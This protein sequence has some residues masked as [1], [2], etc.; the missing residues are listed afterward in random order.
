MS[1]GRNE[2]KQDVNAVVAEARIT[3]DT[4]LLRK[5]VIVLSLE[6]T[7]DLRE[8]I[9]RSANYYLRRRTSCTYLASLSIWSPKPGVSTMV[10]EMRV[11]S[12]S[13]SRSSISIRKRGAAWVHYY[14][15]TVMGWILTPSSKCAVVGSSESLC[16]RTFLPQRVLTKV[17][18]PATVMVSRA[19]SVGGS[20]QGANSPVPDAPQTIKQN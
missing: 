9:L 12:S 2:V 13:S 10:K 4:R 14:V 5:D 20:S 17:V 3:L 18:R 7:N 11:P 6:V 16:G 19:R 8:A 1:G 15:P